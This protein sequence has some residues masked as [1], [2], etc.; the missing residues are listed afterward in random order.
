MPQ[1]LSPAS[2]RVSAGVAT[3]S[4]SSKLG[5]AACLGL[6]SLLSTGDINVALT[7]KDAFRGSGDAVLTGEGRSVKLASFFFFFF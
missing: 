7:S 4:P 5:E 1:Q 2:Q 6:A 3:S